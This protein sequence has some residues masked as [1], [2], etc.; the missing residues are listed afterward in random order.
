M[1]LLRDTTHIQTHIQQKIYF[2]E[3]LPI[4]LGPEVMDLFELRVLK[5]G[6]YDKYNAKI[7]PAIANSF[8]SAAFRFGHSMVQN[9]FVRT[10]SHH[11]PLPN[12]KFMKLLKYILNLIKINY[13]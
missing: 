4:V 11:I 8:S 10:D 6:Y 2:R 3:Y 5:K 1:T 9:S 13:F 7:S 12:S